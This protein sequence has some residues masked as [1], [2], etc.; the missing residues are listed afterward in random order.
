MRRRTTRAATPS[1]PLFDARSRGSALARKGATK[2]VLHGGRGGDTTI[3][4]QSIEN[5]ACS[6][7]SATSKARARSMVRRAAGRRGFRRRARVAIRARAAA[8]VIV[9]LRSRPSLPNNLE[10]APRRNA[11]SRCTIV[12]K[13]RAARRTDSTSSRRTGP[14][15]SGR[16]GCPSGRR[17]RPCRRRIASRRLTSISAPQSCSSSSAQ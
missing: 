11:S 13:A 16:R 10:A 9:N 14:R 6:A 17:S 15:C 3:C 1:R 7:A 4:P 5:A 2:L 12:V 8:D